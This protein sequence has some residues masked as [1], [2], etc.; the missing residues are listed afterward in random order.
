VNEQSQP[1]T[2]KGVIFI[3]VIALAVNATIGV[4]VLGYCLVFKVEPN[5]TLLTAFVGMVNYILGA[6]SGMLV[7]TSPTE[8]TKAPVTPTPDSP[9][10][11]QVMNQPDKPVPTTDEVKP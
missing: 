8:T 2:N 9:A 4:C 3:V 1:S 7:K 10:P 5:T 11:V 6:V